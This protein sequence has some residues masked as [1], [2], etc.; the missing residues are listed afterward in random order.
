MIFFQEK[1]VYTTINEFLD[2]KN[3]LSVFVLSWDE[4]NDSKIL[5]WWQKKCKFVVTY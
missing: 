2:Y 4:S 3:S 1:G 5:S